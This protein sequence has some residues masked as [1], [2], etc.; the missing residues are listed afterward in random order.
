MIYTDVKQ[1]RALPGY[2]TASDCQTTSGHIH[3]PGDQH[4]KGFDS[5]GREDFE[6]I[7]EKKREI[8]SRLF[9]YISKE[10][11]SLLAEMVVRSGAALVTVGYDLCPRGK[12]IN[13]Y[14]SVNCQYYSLFNKKL[15]YPKDSTRCVKRSFK[16][17][18]GHPLL[19]QSTRYYN[20]FLSALSSRPYS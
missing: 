11:G 4:E 15:S 20:D 3:I 9:L 19:C 2:Y 16:V 13:S 1:H 18:Q 7:W 8:V 12:H 10:F 14:S 17:T 6:K 5:Y